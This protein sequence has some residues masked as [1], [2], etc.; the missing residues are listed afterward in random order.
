MQPN[1]PRYVAA[2]YMRLSRDDDT[3]T[4]SSSITTQRAML[5]AYAKENGFI[6][7]DEFIDDGWSGTNYERPA[8]KRMIETIEQGRV[9]LVITKDLSRLGRDYITTGQYT[10]IYFPSKGIRYIA[11]NDGYDSASPF[12]D[13][14]PFKNV[15]NEMYARDTSKKIRSAFLA[16]MNDGSY[17]GN[18]A[19]Y[20]YKKDPANK[21]HLLIDEAVAPIV[22]E[23]FDMASKGYKPSEIANYLNGQGI[24]TPAVYRCQIHEH[25]NVDNY[26]TRKEWTSGTISKLLRNVVYIGNMAQKKTTKVSFK[27]KNTLLNSRENWIVVENTHEPIVSHEC[28]ELADKRTKSRIQE[29][30]KGFVNIFS[31]IAKCADCGKNMSTVGTRKK[32]ATAN[33]ACGGYKLYG[34]SECSN[35]FIDYDTLND[36]V[37]NAVKE[38]IQ[39]SSDEKQRIALELQH[40][41]EKNKETPIQDEICL[42]K[43]R[44]AQLDKMIEKLYE[45]NFQG[46]INDNRFQKLLDKYESESRLINSKIDKHT[47]KSSTAPL[48]YKKF[49]ELVTDFT[50]IQNITSDLLYKLID[51]IEVGQGVFE[52][53]EKG[54]IKR[55]NVTIYFKFIGQPCVKEYIA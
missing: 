34:S 25:L 42:L 3:S 31:G 40:E 20:G 41:T 18:F 1:Q 14:V 15:I 12:D 30:S 37:L 33:L 5:R 48:S 7:Y 46:V 6:V 24:V 51:H 38:Q 16:K 53:T 10:E 44:I 36:I 2:L 35:H 47:Q 19:P 28:F 43:Q 26:S 17:I 39:L 21:N 32:N 13:I 55:Q 49:L 54:R 4:E 27:S 8:F 52:K 50:D 45:D 22:K 9:N 11:I 23:I 29:R